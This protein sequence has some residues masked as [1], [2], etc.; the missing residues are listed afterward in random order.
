MR[1]FGVNP[2]STPEDRAMKLTPE[3]LGDKSGHLVV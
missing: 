2:A 1:G 3:S